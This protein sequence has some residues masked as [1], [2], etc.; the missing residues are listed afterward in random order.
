[1]I[2]VQNFICHTLFLINLIS[3]V[4]ADIRVHEFVGQQASN[5]CNGMSQVQQQDVLQKFNA[6]HF[7]VL[8]A[9]CIAEEGL[10]IEEVSLL[11]Y[12]H[13]VLPRSGFVNATF[14]G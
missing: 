2:S 1:M 10:D 8:V 4:I 5:D 3:P 12:F 9:T 7:N 14:Y 11:Y 6:G 13:G